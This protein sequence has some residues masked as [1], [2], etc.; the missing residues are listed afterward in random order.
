M[1]NSQTSILDKENRK[2]MYDNL[3][4]IKLN[5]GTFKMV[6]TVSYY[7]DPCRVF[8]AENS[9][10]RQAEAAAVRLYRKLVRDGNLEIYEGEIGKAK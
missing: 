3:R 10:T 6:Q 2:L 7:E 4:A 8:R 5:D 9:N 1:I